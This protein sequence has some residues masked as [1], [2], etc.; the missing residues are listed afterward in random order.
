MTTNEDD[1]RSITGEL[2]SAEL[3]ATN[4]NGH[5]PTAP[6]AGPDPTN[7]AQSPPTT[8]EN[9]SYAQMRPQALN[10]SRSLTVSGSPSTANS[11]LSSRDSSPAR[12]PL[13]QSGTTAKSGLRSR[14]S[15]TDVSP[16]RGPSLAGS[17]TTVP[18]AAAIQRAL[19]SANAPQLQPISVQDPSKVPRPQ[20]PASGTTSGE[21]TSH[22]PISPR[23]KS[24]PPSLDSR[25]R[26]RGN[27]LRSQPRKPESNPSAPSIIVQSSSPASSSRIPSKNE[28][29]NSDSEDQ[30]PL[31]MKGSARGSG[32]AAPT[33]ETVQEASLPTSPGFEALE[34][35][36]Y[37]PQL[38]WSFC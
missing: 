29:I 8:S 2:Q 23:L 7:K 24:P 3:A 15:S 12:P 35:Q 38:N 9:G 1:F 16:N 19:S 28:G 17:S 36:R 22:W 11:P 18:S 20:K 25:S 14:K 6:S 26:S 31:T 13:R 37:C 5:V 30:A 27:S 33:L 10:G 4:N 32:S 21:N 34:S